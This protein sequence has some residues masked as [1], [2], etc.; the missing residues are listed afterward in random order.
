VYYKNIKSF[1]LF[2][3]LFVF[4]ISTSDIQAQQSDLPVQLA[5]VYK[6]ENVKNYLVS[7]KYDGIRAIWKNQ[8]LRTRNGNLINAPDWFTRDFPKVWLDGELW[9]SRNQFEYVASTI[10]KNTADDNEWRNIK[11]MVFDA[12]NF[13]SDFTTRAVFY[14]QLI[15]NLSIPHLTAIE[16][17]TVNT[18][19]ELM[20]LLDKYTQAGAEGLMLQKK[21]AKYSEGRNHNVLKLKKHMDAEARVIAHLPGKGKYKGKMG[22]L[23]V[24]YRKPNEQVIRFKIGTGF[25]D[26]ERS[27]PPLVGSVI[28]FKYFGLTNSGIPRF[29]SFMRIRN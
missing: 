22:A 20:H 16:Q 7:E 21:N 3:F 4:F 2:S 5:E 27:N 24:E 12:P 26:L 14:R 8:E 15:N 28:T 25:S 29:A 23:L 13:H 1:H 9:F 10:S 18:N 11:Y 19:A 17:F 6:G